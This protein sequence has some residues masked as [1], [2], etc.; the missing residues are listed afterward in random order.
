MRCEGRGWAGLSC[1]SPE[2]SSSITRSSA[3]R[4]GSPLPWICVPA[5]PPQA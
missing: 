2:A 1:T 5:G 4:L 3:Q